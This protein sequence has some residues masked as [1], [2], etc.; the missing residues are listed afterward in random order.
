MRTTLQESQAT[1][2]PND[3][4]I[5]SYDFQAPLGEFGEERASL[6]RLKV[7]QYFLNDFGADLAPMTVH[8]PNRCPATPPISPFPAPSVR[9]NGDAGFIFFNNYVRNYAMPARQAAQF[10]IRLPARHAARCR[11][12][13]S[14]FPQAPISSGP[15]TCASAVSRFATAPRNC[16]RASKTPV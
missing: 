10:H 8:A 11:A 6:R 16:S 12:I 4:P 14:I 1:G 5:K 2:Y 3:L 15:S 9:S 7:F 13:P